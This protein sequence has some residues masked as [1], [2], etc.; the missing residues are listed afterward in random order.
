MVERRGRRREHDRISYLG[1]PL[2]DDGMDRHIRL[3]PA[4][5]NGSADE[6]LRELV[7]A[8]ADC[9]PCAE[10][11]VRMAVSLL[12]DAYVRVRVPEQ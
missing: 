2:I 5:S 10:R 1:S 7:H 9:N 6:V 4:E 8:S 12:A 3:A 11:R